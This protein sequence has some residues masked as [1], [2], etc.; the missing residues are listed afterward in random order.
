[1]QVPLAPDEI[2]V[3]VEDQGVDMDTKLARFLLGDNAAERLSTAG[4][5]MFNT[6]FGL[7]PPLGP[8]SIR[9]ACAPW[10]VRPPEPRIPV[11]LDARYRLL[12][13]GATIAAIEEIRMWAAYDLLDAVHIGIREEAA[14]RRRP[15]DIESVRLTILC[16]QEYRLALDLATGVV[17]G[18]GSA[19][20]QYQVGIPMPHSSRR[21]PAG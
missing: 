12:P 3:M 15:L 1:M 4:A 2:F 11:Q 17:I 7:D 8:G 21:A 13:D 5:T 10:R 18:T 19:G 6:L 14:D 9:A 16:D 20:F